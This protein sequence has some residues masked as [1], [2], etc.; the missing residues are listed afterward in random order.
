MGLP[1]WLSSKES[2]CNAG[3]KQVTGSIPGSGR[4]PGGGNG[5]PLQRSCLE[6]PMDR[7]AWLATVLG[8]E[9]RQTRLSDWT[10]NAAR[11]LHNSQVT[12][13]ES[14]TLTLSS[15]WLLTA[16]GPRWFQMAF[17]ES[18]WLS[19]DGARVWP[20]RDKVL[21]LPSYMTVRIT[22][23]ISGLLLESKSCL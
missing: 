8:V 23:V 20:A 17:L 3:D 1:W 10:H 21:I 4:S 2:S 6:N 18:A 5:N 22:L 7:G 13:C 12:R 9:K 11:V 14:D 19:T 16:L 15:K